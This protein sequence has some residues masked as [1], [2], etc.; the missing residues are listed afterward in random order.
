MML[1][2]LILA[3]LCSSTQGMYMYMYNAK[4]KPS[5]FFL[6]SDQAV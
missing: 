3:V 2:L 1:E 6:F 4:I 5:K